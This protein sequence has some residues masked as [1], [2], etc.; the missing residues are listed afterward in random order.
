MSFCF[1]IFIYRPAFLCCVC[2]QRQ[3]DRVVTFGRTD[4]VIMFSFCV[5]ELMND[6]YFVIALLMIILMNNLLSALDAYAAAS[7]PSSS[8]SLP[9][10]I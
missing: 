5:M 4:Q 3:G 10:S 8:S 7:S 6:D 2:H 1:Y 9:V